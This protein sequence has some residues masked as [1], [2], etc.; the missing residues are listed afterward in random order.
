MTDAI[1]AASWFDMP[2]TTGTGIA[3]RC[4]PHADIGVKTRLCFGV[5]EWPIEETTLVVWASCQYAFALATTS[6]T[7]QCWQ[8]VIEHLN[9]LGSYHCPKSSCIDVAEC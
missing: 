6:L 9:D 1:V 8:R 4:V 2:F 7:E 5:P 3:A